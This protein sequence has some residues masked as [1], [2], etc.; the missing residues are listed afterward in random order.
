VAY[1]VIG[2]FLAI[3]EGIIFGG[4]QQVSDPGL[5]FST[6]GVTLRQLCGGGL[7]LDKEEAAKAA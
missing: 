1:L 2:H 4:Y 7:R 6:S 5:G 3:I